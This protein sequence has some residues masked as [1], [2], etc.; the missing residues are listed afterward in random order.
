V[1]NDWVVRYANRH[2]QLERQSP[3]PPARST[4]RIFEDPTGQI[5]I[6][7]R[8][9]RLRWTEI[10]APTRPTPAPAPAAHAGAPPLAPPRRHGPVRDHPWRDHAVAQHYAYQQFVK[11]RRA[12]ERV[13]P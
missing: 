5:E 7:Y 13:Q 3:H 4:V 8:D 2:F 1:S 12:W 10:P 9:R 11:D 6:H